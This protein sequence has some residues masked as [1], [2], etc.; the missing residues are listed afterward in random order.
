[1]RNEVYHKKLQH[2]DLQKFPPIS[3]SGRQ[4]ILH[5][6]LQCHPWIHSFFIGGIPI[7]PLEYGYYI[8]NGKDHLIPAIITDP[9]IH[10][11]I[12]IITDPSIHYRITIITDPSIH[13]RITIITDPSIHYRI[14]IITDPSIH[15][16]ITII[17]D[18]SIHYRI[19]IITDPSIPP[20]FPSPCKCLKYA[21]AQVCP[22]RIKQ[23]A[24]PVFF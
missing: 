8:L 4:H 5:A 16:R 6:Y 12:T 13:Y 24:W 11:R 9:S 15:Y 7:G 22:C 3:S 20:D 10:Y 19:T 23:I 1:M 18:P 17:T 2:F 14:T 21:R